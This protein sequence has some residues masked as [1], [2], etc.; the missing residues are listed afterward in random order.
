MIIGNLVRRTHPLC[1]GDHLIRL[2]LDECAWLD[3]LLISL[4]NVFSKAIHER[5]ATDDSDNAVA[6]SKPSIGDVRVEE[7]KQRRQREAELLFCFYKLIL[8]N[9]WKRKRWLLTTA[10]LFEGDKRLTFRYIPTVVIIRLFHQP[11]LFTFK[12]K[13]IPCSFLTM[14]TNAGKKGIVLTLAHLIL[15]EKHGENKHKCC[16]HA[17]LLAFS[18]TSYE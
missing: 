17:C 10:C 6:W 1:P 12:T 15:P 14:G 11:S 3:A 2:Q 4:G 13:R 5:E 8:W 9:W 18:I 16:W 7:A